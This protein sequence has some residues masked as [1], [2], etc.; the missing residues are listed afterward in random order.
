MAQLDECKLNE[1]LLVG[2]DAV[3]EVGSVAEVHGTVKELRRAILRLKGH[4]VAHVV[5][6]FQ[7]AYCLWVFR[8]HKVAEMT[9]EAVDEKLRVE[10]FVAYFLIYKESLL[11]VSAEESVDEACIVFVVEYVKVFD[12]RLVGDVAT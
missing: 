4:G 3:V 11:H 12:G 7:Q 5:G 1:K 9:G 8:H 2:G 6:G 10:A